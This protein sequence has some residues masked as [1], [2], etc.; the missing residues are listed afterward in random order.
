MASIRRR[1]SSWQV[2]VSTP[3]KRISATFST[4]AEARMWAL[5]NDLSASKSA[6][7][8]HTPDNFAEVLEEFA[9][10]V[11]PMRP[12][13]DVEKYIIA[14]LIR[15][16]WPNKPLSAL[17]VSD[18]VRFRDAQ[19]ETR[20]P[21]TVKRKLGLCTYTCRLAREEW[22]WNVPLETFRAQTI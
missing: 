10:S 20:K 22:R 3:T 4:L 8:H 5:E 9:K 12:S 2:Q 14:S 15:E 6:T 16:D 17:G 13:R 19:L 21:A 18:L 7:L 11:L 1:N